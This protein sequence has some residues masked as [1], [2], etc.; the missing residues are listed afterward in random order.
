MKDGRV[1]EQ[2]GRG[3]GKWSGTIA[4]NIF[5]KCFWENLGKISKISFYDAR[6]MFLSYAKIVV[7]MVPLL[8]FFYLSTT[9]SWHKVGI[10]ETA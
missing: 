6:K 8:T 5:W 7:F 10:V 9:K 4:R 2:G 3:K 1:L